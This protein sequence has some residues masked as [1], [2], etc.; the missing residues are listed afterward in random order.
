MVPS[1]EPFRGRKPT[2]NQATEN[3]RTPWHE[4]HELLSFLIN[5][6]IDYRSIQSRVFTIQEKRFLEKKTCCATARIELDE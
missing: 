6:T 4:P 1:I 3:Y 2:Y 5:E